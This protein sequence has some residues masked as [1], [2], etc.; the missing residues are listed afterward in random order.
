MQSRMVQQM[1]VMDPKTTT[2]LM[3]C[4][5]KYLKYGGGNRQRTNFEDFEDYVEHRI[6]DCGSW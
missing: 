5:A 4:W 2:S 1:M 6:M 3:R